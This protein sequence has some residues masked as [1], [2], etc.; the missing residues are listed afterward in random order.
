VK[1]ISAVLV[2]ILLVL[3]FSS[4]G[5]KQEQ[6]EETPETAAEETISFTNEEISFAIFFDEK[7]TQRQIKLEKGQKELKAYLFVRFP[8]DL[9]IA[10]VEYRINLPDGVR[11]WSDRF[12][13]ER[14]LTMGNFE[15][16]MTEGFHCVYGPE[17]LLHV[18]TL[19]IEKDLENAT[20]SI[21]PSER[22]KFLG[23]A[24]CDDTFTEVRATSFRAVINPTD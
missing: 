6:R 4:C 8:E 10:A 15:H 5:E 18:L 13:E 2:M 14:S 16:G 20:I 7:G 24:K 11:I 1:S 23:V 19:G 3:P 12:Y 21:L 9:G 22:T 17:L